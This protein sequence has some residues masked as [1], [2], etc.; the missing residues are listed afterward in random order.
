M[1]KKEKLLQEL[2]ILNGLYET[3]KAGGERLFRNPQI[4]AQELH[5][6]FSKISKEDN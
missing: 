3:L 1:T 6:L 5:E 4:S 2:D